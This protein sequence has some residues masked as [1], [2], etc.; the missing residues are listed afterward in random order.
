M[1]VILLMAMTLDGK[2]ARTDTHFP[3]W[4]GKADK[5]LFVKVTKK[6]GVIIMGSKT[7]DTIGKPLPERKNIVCT[8]SRA[9][10]LTGQADLVFTGSPPASILSDL[11]KE[12]YTEAVLAGGAIVNSLFAR[13]GLID[14][15][16]I[17]IAPQV[18]GKGISLFA[19]EMDLQLELMEFEILDLNYVVVHY[20][21]IR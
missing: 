7:F 10:Q 5:K 12:G 2:I 4:T 1:K 3:D 20:R 9:R 6:A 21:V 14:E 16:I 13:A 19:D 18:F 17:T 15:I 11:E 8:R